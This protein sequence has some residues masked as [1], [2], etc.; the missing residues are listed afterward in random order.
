[1]GAHQAQ[2]IMVPIVGTKGEIK[3]R[4]LFEERY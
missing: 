3:N 4:E 2:P 1:M